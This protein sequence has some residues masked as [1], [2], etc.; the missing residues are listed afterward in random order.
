MEKIAVRKVSK[1][2]AVVFIFV[3]IFSGTGISNGDTITPSDPVSGNDL[4]IRRADTYERYI[5]QYPDAPRPRTEVE[6]EVDKYVEIDMKAEIL[7]DFEGSSGKSLKTD[8]QG[9]VTWEVDVP[10]EGLYSLYIE[11]FPIEGRSAAIEREVWING[12]SPFNDAKHITFTRVWVNAEEIR[13]DNRDN[14]MRPR[15]I[16]QPQWQ[17]SYFSDYMG[18]YNEPYLFHFN[19]GKNTIKLVSVKELW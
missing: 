4:T 10:E 15:Q 19:K 14:D 1:L 3:F 8:E 7:Q 11:Y 12:I 2:L 13:R 17:T 9:Y 16:E 6:I 5:S 18:Y